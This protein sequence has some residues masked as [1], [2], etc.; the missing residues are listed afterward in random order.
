M[1]EVIEYLSYPAQV[2]I[3]I[4][5]RLAPMELCSWLLPVE[6][7]GYP[8]FVVIKLVKPSRKSRKLPENWF[9]RS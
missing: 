5:S 6:K 1:I 8:D 2:L 4:R 9:Y 7:W 3:D